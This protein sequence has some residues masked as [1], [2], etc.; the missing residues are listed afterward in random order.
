MLPESPPESG[1]DTTMHHP[2]IVL[3]VVVLF[4]HSTKRGCRPYRQRCACVRTY[5][6]E[7][8][9]QAVRVDWLAA[10]CLY[11]S[12][13]STQCCKNVSLLLMLPFSFEFFSQH[14]DF[15]GNFEKLVR[16]I[17][18]RPKFQLFSFKFGYKSKREK[19]SKDTFLKSIYNFPHHI[20]PPQ[21][22]TP[23]R[24]K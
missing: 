21:L 19:L 20:N 24:A 4:G 23:S 10:V 17:Q 12:N 7:R 18:R 15:I 11:V 14:R 6:G 9:Q 5:P 2:S 16:F 3:I 8:R 22:F 1:S 13:T